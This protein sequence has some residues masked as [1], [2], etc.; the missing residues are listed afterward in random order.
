M[1]Y[2]HIRWENASEIAQEWIIIGCNIRV[3]KNDVPLP[4]HHVWPNNINVDNDGELKISVVDQSSKSKFTAADLS[5]DHTTSTW[6]LT[7]H[8][9]GHTSNWQL[10]VNNSNVRVKC[11]LS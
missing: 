4:S 6:S 1:T 10:I 8:P 11:F 2:Y 9:T 5:Y 7:S 3:S